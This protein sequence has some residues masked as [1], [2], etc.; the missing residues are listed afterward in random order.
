MHPVSLE[1]VEMHVLSL[2]EEGKTPQKTELQ[3]DLQLY[4]N[5]ETE[6]K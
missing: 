6:A 4:R 2:R 3:T 1:A 5:K